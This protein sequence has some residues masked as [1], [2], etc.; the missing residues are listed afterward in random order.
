M[1]GLKFQF[2]YVSRSS[3]FKLNQIASILLGL[4]NKPDETFF[5]LPRKSILAEK[6]FLEAKKA[7]GTK[8]HNRKITTVQQKIVFK[9]L[10]RDSKLN[11]TH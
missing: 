3:D 9:L 4:A 7:Y 10:E 2:K 8:R 11:D 5:C 6:A 1:E